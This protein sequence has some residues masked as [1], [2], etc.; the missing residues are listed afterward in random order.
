MAV[1]TTIKRTDEG[2]IDKIEISSGTGT[3]R[4]AIG[5]NSQASL[6]SFSASGSFAMASFYKEL[7]V[8][9]QAVLRVPEVTDVERL[10]DAI[11]QRRS[12]R[13]AEE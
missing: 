10:E 8:A 5:E 2:E 1:E 9:E 7:L 12:A 3:F 4:Y 13:A 6:R 11:K